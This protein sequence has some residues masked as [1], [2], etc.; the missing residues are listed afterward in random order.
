MP[1]RTIKSFPYC[2]IVAMFGLHLTIR[3]REWLRQTALQIRGD[4]FCGGKESVE[5]RK[6]Q[7]MT[8][9]TNRYVTHNS[10]GPNAWSHLD[11]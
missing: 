11:R 5:K 3:Q 2:Q 9:T 10:Q 8:E 7:R 4:L 6:I 1:S